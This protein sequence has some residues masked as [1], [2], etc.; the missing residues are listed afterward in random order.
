MLVDVTLRSWYRD[1]TVPLE[2]IVDGLIEAVR[3]LDPGRAPAGRGR[4][5]VRRK[6]ESSPG[7]RQ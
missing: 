3:L 1:A 4:G 2:R 5:R 7:T 6:K